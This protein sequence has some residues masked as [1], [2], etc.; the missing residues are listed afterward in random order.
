[1]KLIIIAAGEGSRIRS[2]TGE[3]P[4][5]LIS[6]Q[7]TPLLD[8]LIQN[9]ASVGLSG[10]VVVTGYHHQD[11]DFHVQNMDAPIPIETVYNP[12]WTLA[13]GVSVLVARDRI[14]EDEAFILSMSDHFY[15]MDFLKTVVQTPLESFIAR[16]AVDFNIQRIFDPDDA[17]KVTVDP[18]N[19]SRIT[20]M[21]KTLPV[22]D[23]VDCGVFH[24]HYDFFATL[25]AAQNQGNTS[26]ADACNRL[27][28]TER[29]GGIDI[30][31]RF[32]LDIDIPEALDQL[33]AHFA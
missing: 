33:H 24:C 2:R 1:M 7:G 20:A 8:I 31:N 4:K 26:L 21:A 22:Y 29:M 13:N 6:I 12:D 32:W 15:E 11:L 5:S 16:V 18:Q 23:A 27:I 28:Q 25:D 17:M 30:G 10:V 14:P 19:R 3:R 9:A